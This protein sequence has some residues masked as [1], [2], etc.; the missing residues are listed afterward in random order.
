MSEEKLL[1]KE[2]YEGEL[3]E[4]RNLKALIKHTV[5]AEK[6]SGVYFICGEAGLKDVNN[7]PEKIMVCPSYGVDFFY[8]YQY[9][10]NTHGTE[11]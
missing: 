1:E 5:L 2:A 9:T 11:W 10:G 7:M 4:L 6:M 8:E 3:N